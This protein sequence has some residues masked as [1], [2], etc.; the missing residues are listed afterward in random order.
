M[1]HLF[2]ALL[3]GLFFFISGNNNLVIADN[4]NE[5]ISEEISSDGISGVVVY[6]GKSDYHIVKTSRFYVIV[7]WYSGPDFSKGDNITGELHSYGFK[8]VTVGDNSRETKV[9]IENYHI[10][11]DKCM[12]WFKEHDKVK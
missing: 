6:D 12:E 4:Y 10:T 9:Y 5:A 8:M 1:K 3:M 2:I 11:Y 7:E